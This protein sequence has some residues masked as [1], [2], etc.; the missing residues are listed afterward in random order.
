MSDWR[1]SIVLDEKS[2]ET[3]GKRC[4]PST[5]VKVPNDSSQMVVTVWPCAH[6]EATALRELMT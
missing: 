6:Y 5:E 2:V 1:I 3:R 4:G